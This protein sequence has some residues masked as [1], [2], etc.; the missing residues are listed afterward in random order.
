MLPPSSSH[1]P[2]FTLDLHILVLLSPPLLP[3]TV[4]AQRA[5]SRWTV[6]LIPPT[7]VSG[8]HTMNRIFH[9]LS[10]RWP[11]IQTESVLSGSALEIIKLSIK[12]NETDMRVRKSNGFE[13]ITLKLTLAVSFYWDKKHVQKSMSLYGTTFCLETQLLRGWGQ[14]TAGEL[15]LLCSMLRT[16]IPETGRRIIFLFKSH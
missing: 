13:E 2:P 1:A 4:L 12:K 3:P 5:P 11:V 16:F 10:K 8:C 14:G 15:F 9:F 6:F 7:Q